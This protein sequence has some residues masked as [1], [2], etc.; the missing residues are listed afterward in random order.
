MLLGVIYDEPYNAG[1][2]GVFVIRRPVDETGTLK[3]AQ[4]NE[5]LVLGSTTF[6]DLL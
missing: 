6:W 3:N 2:Q 4:Q 5:R 1:A